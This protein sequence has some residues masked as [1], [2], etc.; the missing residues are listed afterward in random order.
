MYIFWRPIQMLLHEA[1][2]NPVSRQAWASILEHVP[3][4]WPPLS[5]TILLTVLPTPQVSNDTPPSEWWEVDFKVLLYTLLLEV[6]C[7]V[8]GICHVY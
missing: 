1:L 7:R 6:C 5:H 4:F 2:S 3:W 8:S